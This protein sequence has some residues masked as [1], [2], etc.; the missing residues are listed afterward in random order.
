MRIRG[1]I[2]LETAEDLVEEPRTDKER[3]ANESV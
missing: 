3:D 2:F 1:G